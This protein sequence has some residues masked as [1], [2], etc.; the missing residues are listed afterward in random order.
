MLLDKFNNLG[1]PHGS[2]PSKYILYNDCFLGI[3]DF[4]CTETDAKFYNDLFEEL[5][6]IGDQGEYE[7]MFEFYRK[8][9][10][11][12]SLKATLGVRTRKAYFFKDSDELKDIILDKSISCLVS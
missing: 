11:A 2:T 1:E 3:N 6:N 4:R 9:A 5:K 12:L 8:L 10:K 7:Y